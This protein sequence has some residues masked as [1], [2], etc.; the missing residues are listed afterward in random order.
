MIDPERLLA[1]IADVVGLPAGQISPMLRSAELDEWDSLAHLEIMMRI[2]EE[3]GV[4][5][6]MEAAGELESIPEILAFLER[7]RS[8]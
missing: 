2:E 5:V 6:D 1:L 3:F 8:A 7:S 4:H